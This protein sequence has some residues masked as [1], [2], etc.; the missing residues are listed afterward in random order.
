MET[1][2]ELERMAERRPG[3]HTFYGSLLSYYGV[4]VPGIS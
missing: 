3:R 4:P 1:L 2:D